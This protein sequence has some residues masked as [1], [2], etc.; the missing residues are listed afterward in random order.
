[1]PMRAMLVVL[2]AMGHTASAQRYILSNVGATSCADVCGTWDCAPV[3]KEHCEAAVKSLL[4]PGQ[5]MG[6]TLQA[7]SWGGTCAGWQPPSGCSAQTAGDWAPHFGTQTATCPHSYQLVC[8]N[9]ANEPS[10]ATSTLHTDTKALTDAIQNDFSYDQLYD[11][12]FNKETSDIN[13]P[14]LL[15]SPLLFRCI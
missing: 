15:P 9:C 8:H 14:L 2:L 11:K 10:W 6:R 13:V 3:T 7:D 5:T 12:F 1:M 4:P